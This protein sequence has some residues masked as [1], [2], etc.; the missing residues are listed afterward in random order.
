MLLIAVVCTADVKNLLAEQTEA[1][2][3]DKKTNICEQMQ[4]EGIEWYDEVH[5]F[6]SVEF[7]Q[8][9]VWFDSFFSDERIDEEA[10]P[11]THVRWQ[12]DFVL[13]KGGKWNYQANVNMSFKLPK[14]KKKLHLVFEGEQEET[15]TDIVP[16]NKEEAKGDLGLL[17]EITES[18]R[19]NFTIRVKLSPSINFRYRYQ[20]PVTDTFTTR[21]TQEW[22]RR[23]NADGHSSRLDFEKKIYED[24]LLRQANAVTHSEAFIGEQWDN[25]LVLYQKLTDKSA[26]SYESSMARVTAPTTYTT[27]KRLGL[28]YRKNFYRKWLF[29][30]IAHA[31]NWPRLLITDERIRT[32]EILLRLEVNFANY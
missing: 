21:F 25:S 12:N 7:C 26:L 22:Y 2:K 11:G 3:E 6:M 18:E 19:A 27:N 32:W 16:D 8:P 29:Y 5:R 1:I 4:V 28:R 14:T 15:V 23:D 9:S 10:R 20:Y 24:F 30:E 31:Y 13:T 17:Y